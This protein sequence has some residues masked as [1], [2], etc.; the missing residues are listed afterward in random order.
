MIVL[1]LHGWDGTHD[2]A[3]ALVVDGEVVACI[4]EERLNR[5]KHALSDRPRL[6]ARAVLRHAGLCWHDVDVVSYG[7]NLPRYAPAHGH[8]WSFADD[9]E[10][11]SSALEIRPDR[12]P[13]LEWVG[14]H[15]A[16]AAAAFHSSGFNQAAVLV[17]DGQ[18]E[19]KSVSLYSA[20]GTGI[21]LVRDWPPCCSLGHLYEAATRHCGF[22]FLQAGK[23][24]GLAAYGRKPVAP[25][26]LEWKGGDIQSP[27]ADDV[28]EEAVVDAW[29]RILSQRYGPPCA[30]SRFGNPPVDGSVDSDDA[31]E[32]H[33]PDVAAAAQEAVE[34]LLTSFVDYAQRTTGC[35]HVVLAG[36]V[37][38]NCVANGLVAQRC[39][40]FFVPPVAHDAGAALGAAMVT[41][42]R[43]GDTIR[44][45]HGADLG[46]AYGTAEC[47]AAIE[48]NKLRARRIDDPAAEA[49]RR[50]IAGEIVGW[51]QG[52]GEIG[53]RALGHRSVLALP[54]PAENHRRV[55]LIKGRETWRPLA[56]SALASET[57]W[58]FGR[59][60]DSP[61]M[62]LSLPL[63]DAGRARL[64][65]VAHVDGSTRV[66]TVAADAALPYARL[67]GQIGDATGSSVV[68]NTSFNAAFEPIVGTPFDAIRTFRTMRLDALVL[69]HFVLDKSS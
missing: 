26:P 17:V 51:F 6:A 7:W 39:E 55:N 46:P 59:P 19:D 40:K 38:L 36:G 34:R 31:V 68:L 37:A 24:M 41:A 4:E 16:H 54:A 65:A 44:R 69:D 13:R 1:G 43:A 14:H 60:V 21:H 15:D 66:H 28:D 9:R 8:S 48:A 45:F 27:V 33:H 58:M 20:D 62:L 18:G 25:L 2:A 57:P 22:G 29:C 30:P 56:P 63:A 11:L 50:L 52:R 32:S 53:P 64:P 23:T 5:R 47:K 12:W 3:A 10:F 35:S 61:Y 42:V 49:A 67:L